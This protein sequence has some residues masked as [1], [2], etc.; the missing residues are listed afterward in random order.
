MVMV[1]GYFVSGYELIE[2]YYDSS[3]K[4]QWNYFTFNYI[5][6]CS[7]FYGG[8]L[9]FSRYFNYS[10]CCFSGTVSNIKWFEDEFGNKKCEIYF[11]WGFKITRLCATKW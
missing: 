8:Q 5:T 1:D 2:E 7:L 9:S 3:D 10:I 4:T 11:N 6:P